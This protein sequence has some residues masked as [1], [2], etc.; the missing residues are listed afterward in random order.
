MAVGLASRH[1][2]QMAASFARQPTP[3]LHGDRRAVVACLLRRRLVQSPTAEEELDVF[4]ILR[5]GAR[6]G[7]S[8]SGQRWAGQ[9]GFPGGHVEADESDHQAVARECMEE[10]GFTLDAPGGYRF[11][12]CVRERLVDRG[13][14]EMA[15]AC[16]VYEQLQEEVPVLQP[17]EVAACGWVPLRILRAKDC[18]R[19]L[20]RT[21]LNATT[22]PLWEGAPSVQLQVRDVSVIDG[23]AEEQARERF[24]LWGLTLNM[25]NDWLLATQLRTSPIQLGTVASSPLV[26]ASEPSVRELPGGIQARL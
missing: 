8:T 1:L 2:A 4:F 11:L 6:P 16:R 22:N 15:V 25:V 18:A 19:P 5:A 9:V 17:D 13:T 21:C 7:S 24:V 12:G 26:C 23:I 14:G 10:V 20:A 3:Q